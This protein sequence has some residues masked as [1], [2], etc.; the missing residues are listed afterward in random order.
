MAQ[1]Y[2]PL[3]GEATTAHAIR[4]RPTAEACT[5]SMVVIAV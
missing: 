5:L 2:I 3:E 4:L 1:L